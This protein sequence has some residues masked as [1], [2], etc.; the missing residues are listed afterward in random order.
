MLPGSGRTSESM[1]GV[2]LIMWNWLQSSLWT[3]SPWP[4]SF[5]FFCLGRHKGEGKGMGSRTNR[6][7]QVARNRI[8]FGPVTKM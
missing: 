7:S 1:D 8:L 3:E 6:W 4:R 5:F 2:I